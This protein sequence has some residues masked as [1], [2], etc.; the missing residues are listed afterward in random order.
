MVN[1]RLKIAFDG[2]AGAGKSTIARITA[3]RLGYKYIDT[4]AMYRALTLKALREV[5][6][7]ETDEERIIKLAQDTDISFC[8]GRVYL[9]GEDVTLP[10]R[11]PEVGQSVSYVARI[12]GVREI[13]VEKQRELAADGGAVL[14]GR[15]IGTVVLPDADVKIF[16]TASIEERTR[17]RFLE[18]KARG[19][20]TSQEEVREEI[21]KRDRIDSQREVG[22]LVMADDAI[23]L[24]S[25]YISIEEVVEE[26]LAICEKVVISRKGD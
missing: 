19:I 16:L 6:G 12:G 22:P 26:V 17:R 25:S 5:E 18:L 15:D 21:E 1:E 9:D 10:I 20:T 3:Q 23:L 7:L 2:P 8:G 13:L 4:G 14:D 11:S 24:D